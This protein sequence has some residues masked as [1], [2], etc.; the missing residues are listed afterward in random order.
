MSFQEIARI[1]AALGGFNLGCGWLEARGYELWRKRIRRALSLYDVVRLDH[2]RAFESYW[3]IPA[4][5]ESA[6]L[7]EWRRGAGRALI[8]ALLLEGAAGRIIAEDLGDVGEEVEALRRYSGFPGMRVLEFGSFGDSSPHLPH[9]FGK[10]T[11]AYTATHDNNTL[12][13]YLYSLGAVERRR[14]FD[15]FGIEGDDID[16]AVRKIIKNML[17]S[18]ADTVIIPVQDIL[19]FGADTR[20]NT[21]GKASGNW[22]FRV[23]KEQL[24]SID[25]A[26]YRRQNELYFRCK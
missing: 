4:S 24:S 3:S 19:G 8:D 25:T 23:T 6:V 7:G 2:F 18:V 26:W 10:N 14:V 22:A 16:S 15:Y 20:M 11:V 13:G 9:N 5:A 12:L 17:A 21:P 1:C